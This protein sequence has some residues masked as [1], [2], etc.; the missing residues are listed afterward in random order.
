MTE[1]HQQVDSV[2]PAS[3][4]PLLRALRAHPRRLIL[5]LLLVLAAGVCGWQQWR[6][7]VAALEVEHRLAAEHVLAERF[8]RLAHRALGGDPAAVDQLRALNADLPPLATVD[9]DGWRDSARAAS[10]LLEAVTLGA[11]LPADMARF[12]SI[13]TGT[14]VSLDEALDTLVTANASPARIRIVA[15]QRVLMQRIVTSIH[16]IHE[17]GVAALGAADRLGRDMAAFGS[18]HLAL[19]EGDRE[20]AIDA[21]ESDDARRALEGIEYDFRAG[22]RLVGRIL[23]ATT[24]L[25]T[26]DAALAAVERGREQVIAALRDAGEA[27]QVSRAAARQWG[28]YAGLALGLGLLGLLGAMVHL[29]T[30]ARRLDRRLDVGRAAEEALR[31][32][33]EITERSLQRLGTDL[34]RVADGAMP[35]VDP[36][37]LGS[38]AALARAVRRVV[39]RTA[40]DLEQMRTALA[41]LEPVLRE[42]RA[43]GRAIGGENALALHRADDSRRALDGL[44]ERFAAI[45][46]EL[47]R[48]AA[49]GASSRGLREA[50]DA[51]RGA[52][53]RL[54]ELDVVVD[55]VAAR[56][57]SIEDA[58]EEVRKLARLA[59]EVAE[60]TRVLWI[61]LSL[62]ASADHAAA[63]VASALGG[64]IDRL[65]AGAR[66]CARRADTCVDG[67][68][69]NAATMR[70]TLKRARWV[71]ERGVRALSAAA[72]SVGALQRDL[73]HAAESAA[74]WPER[75][76][77]HG[78]ALAGLRRHLVALVEGL[79]RVQNTSAAL[80]DGLAR[81]VVRA[82]LGSATP[83]TLLELHRE[84]PAGEVH[85][86]RT[87][88][89][90]ADREP[91]AETRNPSASR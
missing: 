58:G 88:D 47:G 51:C 30:G 15:R 18:I 62:R 43:A 39:G 91:R 81:V 80:G 42:V 9:A 76:R 67:M 71:S 16:R 63:P 28:V 73:E 50:V 89:P 55:E 85:Q 6:L 40:A 61:N 21:L 44:V 41:A 20:L 37:E 34:Q 90:G 49:R 64:D 56:V 17:G 3:G 66:E 69:K 48:N 26:S 24:A 74:P 60:Q 14:L 27:A 78:H 32:E 86:P 4:E 46:A 36:D 82:E 70:A 10:D 29:R 72:D 53:E 77:E 19:L 11:S 25:S 84:V 35:E 45:E 1:Q 57:G 83:V 8:A 23:D 38:V 5:P 2:M 87:V 54:G 33:I 65:L 31:L 75:G 7:G 79:R 13:A 68:R 59:A 12:Q 52:R 22:A